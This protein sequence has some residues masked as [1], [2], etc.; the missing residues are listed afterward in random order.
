MRTQAVMTYG[1]VT[2][3]CRRYRP[4]VAVGQDLL[5]L[6]VTSDHRPDELEFAV[7]VLSDA[8]AALM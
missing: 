7:K 5:R 1:T 2:I 6:D 8:R 3:R 4:V